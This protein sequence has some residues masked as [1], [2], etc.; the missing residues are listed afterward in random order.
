[1]DEVEQW[2]QENWP[3]IL[4][5]EHPQYKM[6]RSLFMLIYYDSWQMEMG[7]EGRYPSEACDMWPAKAA[8]TAYSYSWLV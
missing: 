6:E 7:L 1:M 5:E 3:G 4:S 2:M 8:H